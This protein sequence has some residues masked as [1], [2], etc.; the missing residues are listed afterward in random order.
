MKFTRALLISL[1]V[2]ILATLYTLNNHV[3]LSGPAVAILF[4]GLGIV[5]IQ[6]WDKLVM[7]DIDTLTELENDNRAYAIHQL[8]PALLWLAACIA[9]MG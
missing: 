7:R 9:A 2:G 1:S 8:I 4:F 5:A 3:D 6:I